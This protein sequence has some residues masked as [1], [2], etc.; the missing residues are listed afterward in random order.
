MSETA[1]PT[2][3]SFWKEP[4]KGKRAL[5]TGVANERS[6]AWSIAE[7]LHALGCDLAFTYQAESLQRRVVPLA[8]TV[9]A[10]FVMPFDAKNESDYT[11][12][13]SQIE[14]V[15]GKFDIL[16]H[17]MAF[18]ERGE[19]EG[20]F[21]DTSRAGFLN[22]LDISCYSLVAMS[23]KLEPLLNAGGTVLTLTYLGSQRV[24]PNYNVMGVAKAALEAS[25]RYLALDL[26]AKKIRVNAVSAGP[27][28]T[29]AAAG[30]RNFREMLTKNEERTLLKENISQEDV[31]AFSAFLC[32]PGGAHITGQVLY[33]DSG[34][35]VLQA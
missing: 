2:V 16:I 26:G 13:S 33:V 21:L 35:S 28:K 17:S 5:I 12:L 29:L 34:Q 22:C 3:Q 27:V 31:G 24:I 10:K 19:L 9:Q 8:E 11:A 15:W 6:L 23:Q 18:A 14:K 4:L 25:V 30:I 20:R 1:A 32:T 7:H